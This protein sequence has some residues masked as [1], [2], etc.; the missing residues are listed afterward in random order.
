MA[1]RRKGRSFHQRKTVWW[2]RERVIEGL[3]RFYQDF[4]YASTATQDYQERAQF[5]GVIRDGRSSNKGWEQKYPSSYAVLKHFSTLRE[6]WAAAGIHTD[7]HWEPWT[8]EEDWFILESC[9]ILP[10][11]EV[12]AYL[13]RSEP[14]VKRRIYDLGG[15]TTARGKNPLKSH[16]RWGITVHAAQTALGLGGNV[17]DKYITHGTLPMFRGN[18]CIYLNPADLLVIREVDW[19]REDLLPAD[20]VAWI[21][22]ALVQRIC[23]LLKG[24]NYRF[25]EIYKFLPPKVKKP[26]E[27]GTFRAADVPPR[28]NDLNAGENVVLLA[29]YPALP[30]V[31]A[32]RI[33]II[34]QI[35][36]SWQNAKRRGQSGERRGACWMA[37]VEFP[38]RRAGKNTAETRIYYTLPLEVLSRSAE[39][40]PAS[41][42][43]KTVVNPRYER[44]QERYRSRAAKRREFLKSELN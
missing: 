23:K 3:K 28:P 39:P 16:T 20:L 31:S 29:P 6:A 18:R 41:K 24:E 40:L 25:T 12:A 42:K 11:K 13:D 33:G 1:F 35:Y 7:R 27:K 26:R 10:R 4:G 30:Q 22:L 43:P 2:T 44:N 37:R 9:G 8:A 14:A 19:T 32:G 34:K 36:Y 21:R 17:V 15:G 38:K 5:S